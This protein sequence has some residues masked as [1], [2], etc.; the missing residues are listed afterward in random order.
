MTL[1]ILL[2]CIAVSLDAFSVSITNGLVLNNLN[3]KS[4]SRISGLYAL[5]QVLMPLIGYILGNGFNNI[6]SKFDH[7]IIFIILTWIGISMIKESDEDGFNDLKLKTLIISGIA[8]S[9]D[10][11]AAGVT[12]SLLK[13][14]MLLVEL[15][16]FIITFVLCS[17]GVIIGNKLSDKN[18]NLA[19]VIGGIILIFMGLRSLLEN[20]I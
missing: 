2:I 14:N 6:I 9:L 17:I 11:L 3:I 13:V 16:I 7:V 8:T 5:F 4:I 19:R 15:T 1:Y 20:V 10:A 18:S 12:F